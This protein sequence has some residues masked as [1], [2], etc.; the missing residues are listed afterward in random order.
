MSIIGRELGIGALGEGV[1]D[2]G[3]KV[4]QGRRRKP[5]GVRNESEEW[6]GLTTE[7]ARRCPAALI[8]RAKRVAGAN[9]KKA[10]ATQLRESD[11][12]LV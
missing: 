1:R 10:A 6:K 4:P 12:L 9:D 11:R 5:T 7:E 2:P 8:A 3:V